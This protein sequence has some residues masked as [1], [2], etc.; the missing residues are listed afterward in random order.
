MLRA[1]LGL[2][3]GGGLFVTAAGAQ[4]GLTT[5]TTSAGTQATPL[6]EQTPQENARSGSV[7]ERAPGRIIDAA[8]ARHSALIAERLTARRTGQGSS[9]NTTTNTAA[10]GASGGSPSSSG[11]IAGLINSLSSSGG[12]AGIS[13]LLNGTSGL[14]GLS[15]LLGGSSGT[16]TN[17]GTTTGG[18]T[19]GSGGLGD[20]IRQRVEEGQAANGT[21]KTINSAQGADASASTEATTGGAVGRLQKS[22]QAREQSQTEEDPFRIRLADAV[23]GTVFDALAGGML[24]PAFV[25]FLADGLRPVF[26]LP[27]PNATNANDNA[28][29]NGNTDTNDNTNDNSND[30]GSTI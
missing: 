24:L 16:T 1:M 10:T 12:L 18:S 26:G 29:D 4:T 3:I 5:G 30:N 7:S 27:D 20:L 11:G 19:S 22:T 6:S 2:I 15:G 23:I 13:G 17:S 9:Q 28:N 21:A 25:D 14:S 8:R